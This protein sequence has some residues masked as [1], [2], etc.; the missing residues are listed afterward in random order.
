MSEGLEIKRKNKISTRVHT[1]DENTWIKKK[2]F[3][4][5]QINGTFG[6]GL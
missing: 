3:P 1:H 4:D 6:S 2:K 5:S